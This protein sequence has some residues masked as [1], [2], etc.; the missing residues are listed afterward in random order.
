MIRRYAAYEKA[1]AYGVTVDQV[2]SLDRN[3]GLAWSDYKTMG[4]ELWQITH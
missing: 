1:A 3:A 4:G 2:R